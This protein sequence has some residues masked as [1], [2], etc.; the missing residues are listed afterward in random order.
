MVTIIAITASVPYIAL[1][2]KAVATSLETLLV[3]DGSAG[4]APVIGDIALIV[5]AAMALFA[6]AFGT[7]HTD[8]TEHQ[9]GLMLA[10]ATE[11][12]VKLVAFVAVGAFV[13]FVMFSPH[14]L[15]TRALE[16]PEAGRVIA[17]MPA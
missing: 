8:V 14:E 7:R 5:T 13:T 1:Q 11:S 16:S 15:L 17:Y 3:N 4:F 6:V 2:L 10:I 9:H 12:I